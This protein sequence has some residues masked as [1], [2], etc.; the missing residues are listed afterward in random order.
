MNAP[1]NRKNADTSIGMIMYHHMDPLDIVGPYEVF[2]RLPNSRVYLLAEMM[3]PVI[4]SLGLSMLPDRALETA[5]EVDLLFVPGGPGQRTM[6]RN[7]DFLR[8]LNTIGESAQLI[9]SICTGSLLL[10]AAGL[11]NGYRATTHWLCLDELAKYQATA[12]SERVVIDRNRITGAGVSAG[13][14]LALVI[15]AKLYGQDFARNSTA[16]RVRPSAAIQ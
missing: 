14:D 16:S 1:T 9:S 3:E 4:S 7:T 12:V 8:R 11:L 15:V 5:P 13:L 2:A 10:G 6:S